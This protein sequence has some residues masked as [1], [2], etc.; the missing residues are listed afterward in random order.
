MQ[1][2]TTSKEASVFRKHLTRLTVMVVTASISVAMFADV[3]LA[4][5]RVKF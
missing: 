1:S 2:I 4:T 5:A 3:A